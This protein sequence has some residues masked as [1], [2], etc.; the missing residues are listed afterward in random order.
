MKR[1]FTFGLAAAALAS[2]GLAGW[3]RPPSP[4]S[5]F[6]TNADLLKMPQNTFLGRSCGS[7][8]EL[9]RQHLRV[10]AHGAS[11]CDARRFPNVL[12]RRL[13][14]VR[15]HLE[16]HLRKRAGPGSLR[17]QCGAGPAGRSAGQ[18]LGD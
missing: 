17:V 3:L 18:H 14:T 13:A 11:V 5:H 10:H 7:R 16:R 12:S 6:D 1:T 4:K 8:D 15:V 2:H 9:Q